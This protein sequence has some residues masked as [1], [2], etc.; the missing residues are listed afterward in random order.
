MVLWAGFGQGKLV[1]EGDLEN[2]IKWTVGSMCPPSK[3]VLVSR[4]IRALCSGRE[5]SFL[6]VRRSTIGVADIL[7]KWEVDR[8]LDEFSPC[9]LRELKSNS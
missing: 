1:I 4:E 6:L 5:I 7:A 3:L 8:G 2:R 9:D